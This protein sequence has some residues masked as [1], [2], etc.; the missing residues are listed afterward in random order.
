MGEFTTDGFFS[1]LDE[2][3]KTI[4]IN[5]ISI[6]FNSYTITYCDKQK[7]TILS[8]YIHDVECCKYLVCSIP[9]DNIKIMY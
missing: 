3:T 4:N 2:C 9:V 7:K 6:N 1:I 5:E 8:L